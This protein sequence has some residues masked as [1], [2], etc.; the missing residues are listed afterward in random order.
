M[1]HERQLQPR[2]LVVQRV[3]RHAEVLRGRVH[4][5]PARLDDRT[6]SRDGLA[7]FPMRVSTG[8]TTSLGSMATSRS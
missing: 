3:P 5:E 7:L 6:W 2:D 8:G 4:I 1:T